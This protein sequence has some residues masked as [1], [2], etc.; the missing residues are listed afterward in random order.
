MTP[1]LFL[2]QTANVGSDGS[3][4][5]RYS[6]SELLAYAP[7]ISNDYFFLACKVVIHRSL[8][9]LCISND[10]VDTGVVYASTVKSSAAVSKIRCLAEVRSSSF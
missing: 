8:S 10:A 7:K 5:L 6:E 2:F 3:G 9:N 4:L 1:I